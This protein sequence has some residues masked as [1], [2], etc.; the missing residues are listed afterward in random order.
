MR[1]QHIPEENT[2]SIRSIVPTSVEEGELEQTAEISIEENTDAVA[3][4]KRVLEHE[5]YRRKRRFRFAFSWMA[6][7]MLPILVGVTTG[8]LT[9][10]IASLV[11]RPWILVMYYLTMVWPT[12]KTILPSRKQLR[13]STGIM[14]DLDDVRLVGPLAEMLKIEDRHVRVRAGAA[15]TQL[16]PRLQASDA[17]LLNAAQRTLLC[18]VL[19]YP[20]NDLFRSDLVVLLTRQTKPMADLQVAILKAFEQVGDG[21]AL[22]VVERMAVGPAQTADQQRVKAAAVE[23]LPFLQ[24]RAI[25]EQAHQTLLRAS[26]ASEPNPDILLR[27][28]GTATTTEAQELLRP[29]PDRSSASG[30]FAPFRERARRLSTLV[31]RRA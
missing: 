4:V 7:W 6:L 3:R 11:S 19:A 18:R 28:A 23:C 20:L 24:A 12:L 10:W 1:Q 22:P 26:S 14:S 16:L 27:P 31:L 2:V 5:I 25:R 29:E 13:K 9:D 17:D 15:L 8:R 30:P 21:K